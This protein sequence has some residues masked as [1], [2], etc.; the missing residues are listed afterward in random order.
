MRCNLTSTFTR[1]ARRYVA[2]HPLTT[3][4]LAQANQSNRKQG[5]AHVETNL[6]P[7][8]VKY[9]AKGAKDLGQTGMSATSL[10]RR[11]AG[12]D[13]LGRDYYQTL[14]AQPRRRRGV[15]GFLNDLVRDFSD[16]PQGEREERLEA[17]LAEGL[18]PRRKTEDDTTW[19]EALSRV[20]EVIASVSERERDQ[21][22]PA[23]RAYLNELDKS[24]YG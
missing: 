6:V 23:L 16:I 22:I 8:F 20:E 13:Y 11:L 24:R 19:R 12:V 15:R 18:A 7:T 10:N 5:K 1:S 2:R 21:L 3:T 4:G 9:V 17:W 14:V